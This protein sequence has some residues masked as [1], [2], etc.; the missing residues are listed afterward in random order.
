MTREQRR[1]VEAMRS[2]TAGYASLVRSRDEFG[3]GMQWL[4]VKK[5]EYLTRYRRDSMTGEQKATSISPRSPE[6]EAISIV[7]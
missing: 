7:R 1:L 4:K 2:A 5:W 3:G 6:T